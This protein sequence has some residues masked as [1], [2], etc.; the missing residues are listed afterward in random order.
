MD[1][2][3]SLHCS[4]VS[5]GSDRCLL[6]SAGPAAA[7]AAIV[8]IAQEK[9]S[10]VVQCVAEAT[11]LRLHSIAVRVVAKDL[12]LQSSAGKAGVKLNDTGV[13]FLASIPWQHQGCVM[14]KS[15]CNCNDARMCMGFSSQLVTHNLQLMHQ[16]TCQPIHQ[17]VSWLSTCQLVVWGNIKQAFVSHHHLC[18]HTRAFPAVASRGYSCVQG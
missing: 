18:T 8:Q 6:C 4:F 14:H 9:N 10:F 5:L 17:L 11:R 1:P 16:S 15:A 3:S 7:H 13:L 12:H 2:A